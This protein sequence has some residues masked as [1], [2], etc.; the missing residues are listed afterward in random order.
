MLTEF[1]HHDEFMTSFE[2]L[3]RPNAV[4]KVQDFVSNQEFKASYN[5]MT[6]FFNL[7]KI[8]VDFQQLNFLGSLAKDWSTKAECNIRSKRDRGEGDRCLGNADCII[9]F[10]LA[11]A[12]LNA[13]VFICALRNFRNHW[14]K[15]I[16]G[17]LFRHLLTS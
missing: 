13:V 4:C 2:P 15:K 3:S 1:W 12:Q 11:T 7:H 9:Y 17:K 10:H 6:Y 14:A 8:L 5:S 16:P